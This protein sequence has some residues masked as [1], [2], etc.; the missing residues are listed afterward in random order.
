MRATFLIGQGMDIETIAGRLGH[1]T[2]ATTTNVY[3][4]F[5]KAMDR[6]A[7]DIMEET[8]ALGKEILKKDAK[9]KRD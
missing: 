2:L 9:K 1:S 7:A 3:S 4:H 5:L 8:F 6:Q